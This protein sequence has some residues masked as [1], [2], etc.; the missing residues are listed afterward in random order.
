MTVHKA[1]CYP[2]FNATSNRQTMLFLVK[3]EYKELHVYI[4]KSMGKN[5]NN[6]KSV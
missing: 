3:Y 6:I 2:E 4:E 5:R 1:G